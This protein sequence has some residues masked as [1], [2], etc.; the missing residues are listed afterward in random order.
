MQ[1]NKK[2]K[3]STKNSIIKERVWVGKQNEFDD[4]RKTKLFILQRDSREMLKFLIGWR[5]KACSGL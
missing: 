4:I 2:Q 3:T 5:K 1:R